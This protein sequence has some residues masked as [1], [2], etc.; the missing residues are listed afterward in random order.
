VLR[1]RLDHVPDRIGKAVAAVLAGVG[2]GTSCHE[3]AKLARR[4]VPS[5]VVVEHQPHL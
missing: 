2:L 1:P 3:L 4:H 5:P